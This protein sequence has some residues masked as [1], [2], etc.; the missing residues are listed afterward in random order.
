M[1]RL[2][3]EQK[4][5]HKGQTPLT[6][7][8]QQY[9]PLILTLYSSFLEQFFHNLVYVVVLSRARGHLLYKVW[10]HLD[11]VAL[12]DVCTAY[13]HTEG[14][15]APATHPA[16]H[17]VRA[18]LVQYLFGLS[19]RQLEQLLYTDLMARWF[20]GYGLFE[21]PPDHVTFQRFEMWVCQ[22]HKRAFF[23]E[24]VKQI[25]AAYPEER[26]RT[27]IGDTYAMHANADQE[28]L[29]PL[30]YHICKHILGLA[31]QSLP[32]ELDHSVQGFAWNHL[33]GTHKELPAFLLSKEQRVARL[34]RVAASAFDLSMRLSCVLQSHSTQEFPELRLWLGY[35]QKIISAEFSIH[36]QIAQRL[37]PNQQGSFRIGSATDPEAT[38]RVHGPNP[39]DT[40][41]GYNVQVSIS[42][43]GFVYE[44]QAYTGAAPDQSGVAALVSEQRTHLG[45][46]PPKLIYDQAAGCGKTRADVCAASDGQTLLVSK[47]PS[48]ERRTERFGPYDF[49]LS[50]DGLMLTCPAGKNSSIAYRSQSGEGRDFRFLDHQ[51]WCGDPPIHMKN[52]DR[53]QRC[54]LWERCRGERMG[55]RTMRQVF[56]SNYRNEVF[57]AQVYNQTETF[58]LEMKVRPEVERTVFELTHYNGA[59]R[60][61]KRGLDNADWQAKMCAMAYNI[62]RW[63]RRIALPP[64]LGVDSLW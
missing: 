15:G 36:N 9:L 25:Q 18:L 7:I 59:R 17:L 39:E 46:C 47:L 8:L 23:D 16:T 57:A 22:N 54:P 35:L 6:M 63:M 61:R 44:T 31:I 26:T 51:C 58:E 34:Q 4:S 38:Y 3:C 19:Y 27:Q 50:L 5:F 13:H 53:A 30:L 2:E 43:S 49:V 28:D 33:F 14:P 12:D 62:K 52:A 20:V 41:F 29:T 11:L 56:I 42:T 32:H 45:S 64:L 48:F 1:A 21:M 40:S 55:P 37:P 10:H 24:V 60:C